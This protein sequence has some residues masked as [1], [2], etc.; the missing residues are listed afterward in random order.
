MAMHNVKARVF[1]TSLTK[2]EAKTS[3]SISKKENYR[4]YRINYNLSNFKL[5]DKIKTDINI[6]PTNMNDCNSR[7]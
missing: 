6:D 7:K 5:T 1:R 2:I 4:C 3:E